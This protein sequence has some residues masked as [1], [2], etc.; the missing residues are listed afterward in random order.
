MKN[1]YKLNNL[2]YQEL[3][4]DNDSR[5]NIFF[6][7]KELRAEHGQ[8]TPLDTLDDLARFINTD[9]LFYM[10]HNCVSFRGK[11]ERFIGQLAR[12]AGSEI[13]HFI[14]KSI[15]DNDLRAFLI[16]PVFSHQP[17]WVIHIH[18]DGGM[19]MLTRR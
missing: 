11:V 13:F 18:D 17:S 6:R 9:Q 2:T 4:E 14:Q 19:W 16:A 1:L 8:L 10:A 5:E 7:M 12:A 3:V 15:D